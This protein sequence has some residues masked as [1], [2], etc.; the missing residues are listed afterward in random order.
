VQT[1]AL[2]I[3]ALPV[4]SAQVGANLSRFSPAHDVDR[5]WPRPLL[6][7]HGKDDEIISFEHGERLFDSATQPKFFLWISNE[8][9]AGRGTAARK[10]PG[11]T[12]S[13]DKTE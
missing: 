2:P 1:C 4:A 9:P 10:G 3:S 6:V 7:I 5:L 8:E 12:G 11:R 13:N